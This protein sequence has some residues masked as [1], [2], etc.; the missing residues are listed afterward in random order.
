[1]TTEPARRL[2]RLIRNPAFL[3]CLLWA[4]IVGIAWAADCFLRTERPGMV[5][6]E[7]MGASI[8]FIADV[9]G[10][11]VTDLIVGAPGAPGAPIEVAGSVYVLSGSDLSPVYVLSGEAPGDQYGW[12]VSPTADLDGDG[13]LEFAVGGPGHEATDLLPGTFDFGRV[14]VYSGASGAP[15]GPPLDGDTDGA[16]FGYSLAGGVDVTGDGFPDIA[17]GAPGASAGTGERRGAVYIFSGGAPAPQAVAASASLVLVG[18]AGGDRFGS[19][20]TIL[21]GATDVPVGWNRL[22][23][24]A[25]DA[26]SEPI[27]FPRTG[28]VYIYTIPGAPP[29]KIAGEQPGDGF[30]ADVAAIGDVDRDGLRDLAVG[31]PNAGGTGRVYVFSGADLRLLHQR[32]GLSQ[33]EGFGR[34]VRAIRDMTWDGATDFYVGAPGFGLDP[35]SPEGAFHVYSGAAAP[36]STAGMPLCVVP[37]GAPG[38]RQ[39]FAASSVGDLDGDGLG[40]L[41]VGAPGSSVGAPFG[42]AVRLFSVAPGPPPGRVNVRD[43]D[44]FTDAGTLRLAWDPPAPPCSGFDFAVYRALVDHHGEDSLTD[45]T[46]EF[47]STGGAPQIEL[48]LPADH[49]PGTCLTWIVVATTQNEEGFPGQNPAAARYPPNPCRVFFNPTPCGR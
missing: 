25:V 44:A 46:I 24:G 40:E 21:D 16:L 22:V 38:D 35:L 30:G 49:P 12:A 7:A 45:A 47:C 5:P 36:G 14:Y 41:A 34:T 39:G 9:N 48:P 26:A 33:G 31:A 15:I 27:M 19:S 20:I 6:Y 42:G 17:V 10:D 18:E 43:F 29:F 1:M 13:V 37:G 11:A 28:A 8:A 2:A 32:D 4:L 3:G 23:V